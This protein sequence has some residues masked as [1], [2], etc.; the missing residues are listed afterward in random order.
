MSFFTGMRVLNEDLFT[1]CLSF[2][3]Q[4]YKDIFWTSKI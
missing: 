1:E 3:D 4:E 2:L